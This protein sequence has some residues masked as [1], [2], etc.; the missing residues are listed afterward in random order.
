MPSVR[1]IFLSDIHLGTRA[2]Q[3]DRLLDFL[4]NYS[5]ENVFLIGDIV[6]FWS[7]SRGIHWTPAQN[8]FV[9]KILRRARRGERVV[10]I[11]GNHDEALREYAGVAFGDIVV[12]PEH[13]HE[14]ADGRRFLLL[15]G[16]EFDQ[17]TRHH[18]WVAVLGD[19][20][21]NTLVLANGTLSRIRRRLGRPGYWSLAGYAK[22]R[23]KKALQFIFDFEDAAIHSA[24]QRGL[25]GIICGHI[26]SAALREIGGLTYVNCGDWVDSCTAIV[27]H[28]DGRLELVA[29]GTLTSSVPAELPE[30]SVEPP[31]SE[32]PALVA[33]SVYAAAASVRQENTC[34]S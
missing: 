31:F 29:W 18:R 4:R 7:M 33:P 5:A 22:R 2:C 24:R 19:M 28:A 10:F 32:L 26:H 25:D 20:A 16:D 30:E 17:I 3:A 15:H 8:T 11:P 23:V 6:D 13:V 34:A 14:L 9:Q 27:E 12:V 21:Y 1:S